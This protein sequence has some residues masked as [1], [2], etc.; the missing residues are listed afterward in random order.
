LSGT[1]AADSWAPAASNANP[2][3]PDKRVKKECEA[4]V[5]EG[6]KG[7]S[8]RV[9]YGAFS[10]LSESLKNPDSTIC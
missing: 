6:R 9:L 2:Q 10:A 3:K 5:R 4:R 1:A 7:P 8:G